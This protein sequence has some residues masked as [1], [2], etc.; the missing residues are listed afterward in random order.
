MK[1]ILALSLVLVVALVGLYLAQRRRHL[2]TVS[3]NAVLDA[4]A[5]FQRDLTQRRDTGIYSQIST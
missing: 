1:R 3:P 2:D 5:E 4:A